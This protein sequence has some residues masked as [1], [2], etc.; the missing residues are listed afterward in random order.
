MGY[1]GDSVAV[2]SVFGLRMH[3][4]QAIKNPAFRAGFWTSVALV[5]DMAL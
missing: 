2:D 5:I 4:L 1:K 3:Y